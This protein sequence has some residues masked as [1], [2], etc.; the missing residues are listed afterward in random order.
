VHQ[1]KF[2]EARILSRQ[3]LVPNCRCATKA[4]GNVSEKLLE[5]E[6]KFST[7]TTSPRSIQCEATVI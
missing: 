2:S 1:K 6:I 5:A 4:S 7:S 3:T